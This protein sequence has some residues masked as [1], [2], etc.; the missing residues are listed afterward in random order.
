MFLHVPAESSGEMIVKGREVC[1]GLIRGMVEVFL[2]ES[3]EHEQPEH[4]KE[5]D[6]EGREERV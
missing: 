6:G 4:D 5:K 3:E 2:L 1:E